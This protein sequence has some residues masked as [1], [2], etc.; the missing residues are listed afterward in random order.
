MQELLAF[1]LS[2][3]YFQFL[4]CMLTW[5]TCISTVVALAFQKNQK[6]MHKVNSVV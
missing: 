4:I 2:L 6:N 1:M 3:F 5:F